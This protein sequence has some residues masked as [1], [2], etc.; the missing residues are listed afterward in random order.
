MNSRA[1][2]P[3]RA[4]SGALPTPWRLPGAARVVGG[5]AL[6]GALTLSLCG[7]LSAAAAGERMTAD[8]VVNRGVASGT[9]ADA[10]DTECKPGNFQYVP[11][12]APALTALQSDVVWPLATGAGITVAVVDSGVDAANPHLAGVVLPGADFVG[13]G[14]NSRGMTDLYGHGTAVA[15]E[16][17]GQQITGSGVFGFA[18]N[19]QILPVRVFRAVD[20]TSVKAG[21][22]PSAERIA[23]GIRFSADQGATIINVSMS[24]TV[25]SPELQ[26]AVSYATGLGS[27]VVASAGNRQTTDDQ[28][29]GPRFPA[30][31]PEVLGVTAANSSNVVTAD[32][33]HGPQVDVSAPGQNILTAAYGGAD[34]MYAADAPS[35]SF[36]TAYASAAAALVAE[37]FP[38]EGPAGWKFRL[39]S[40][41]A[42]ADPDQRDDVN[43]WGQIQPF[44]ALTLVDDGSARGPLSPF[45]TRTTST[46]PPAQ[47]LTLG[48]QDEPIE[49]TQQIALVIAVLGGT[50]LLVALLATLLP[51]RRRRSP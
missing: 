3:R 1:H 48:H 13:D 28:N 11:D 42:R 33:I 43:G 19:A 22:G 27:L 9:T 32:S 36:A 7:G 4:P 2:L 49:R 47:E 31:Y 17:A 41:A 38:E 30:A 15:G 6:A 29:D 45:H 39:E 37:R 46:P 34:C 24:D 35:S 51:R 23:A 18:H 8:G 10:E 25:D 5:V 16:I 26:S 12:L 14:E 40:T 44:E 50:A 20:E 21:F